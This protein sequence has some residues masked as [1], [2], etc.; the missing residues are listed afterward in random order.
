MSDDLDPL[1]AFMDNINA[2]VASLNSSKE[3]TCSKVNNLPATSNT[4]GQK[5]DI[6][7]ASEPEDAVDADLLKNLTA[8]ELMAYL[9]IGDPL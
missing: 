1:D 3:S 9:E 6:D 8:E 4:R 5:V 7:E 2:E